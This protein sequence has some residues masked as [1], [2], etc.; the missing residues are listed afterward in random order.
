MENRKS[1]ALQPRAYQKAIRERLNILR[2]EHPQ[3]EMARRTNMPLTNVHRLLRTGKIP[4]EF[5]AALVDAFAVNPAWLLMGEGGALLS[6]V[7]AQSAQTG[8]GLLA[9]VES[10]NAVSRLRLGALAGKQHQK[11]LRELN[12]AFSAYERLREQ[13][14]AQSKPVFSTLLDEFAQHLHTLDVERAQSACTAAREVSR[15]CDDEALHTRFISLQSDL[16]YLR[17]SLEKSLELSRRVFSQ[18]LR[19]GALQSEGD[20]RMAVNLAMSLKETGRHFEALRTT[21]AALALAQDHGQNWSA[22]WDLELFR[23]HL[24]VELGMATQGLARIQRVWPSLDMGSFEAATFATVIYVRALLLC[25]LLSP[26]ET[27]GIGKQGI[28]TARQLLRW[29]CWLEDAQALRKAY[30]TGVG[31]GPQRLAE[32]D[33]EAMR[34]RLILRALEGKAT[35]ADF[36]RGSTENPFRAAAASV[37]ELVLAAHKAQFARLAKEPKRAAELA[38]RFEALCAKLPPDIYVNLDLRSLHQR[39]V[40]ALE[41]KVKSFATPARLAKAREFFATN[42]RNG[43]GCFAA[44]QAA[45]LT[46]T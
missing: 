4:A 46:N 3:S 40:L 20:L 12:D 22:Y 45:K 28:G 16:E 11:V 43:Y 35:Y 24:E 13:L 5:C 41:G 18:L 10:M 25:G 31:T 26:H 14:N 39:N 17:G 38:L 32:S 36:E 42:L 19:A 8:Q 23:G 34:A 7:T 1:E 21:K 44:L 27:L 37:R 33:Y 9:L 30:A 6:D 29:T 15:L 2:R